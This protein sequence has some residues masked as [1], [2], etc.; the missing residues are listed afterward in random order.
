MLKSHF[1]ISFYISPPF[2]AIGQ[3]ILCMIANFSR[4]SGNES[5]YT[6]T[7]YFSY[8]IL[9]NPELEPHA[10]N[11]YQSRLVLDGSINSKKCDGFISRP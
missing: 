10:P 4:G 2:P 3:L 7:M 8:A 6:A 5:S 9:A 1:K 11:T